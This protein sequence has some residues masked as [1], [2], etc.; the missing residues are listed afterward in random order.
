MRDKCRYIV[1]YTTLTAR[2]INFFLLRC[3]RS[4]YLR[5]ASANHEM[6]LTKQFCVSSSARIKQILDML[7]SKS[8]TSSSL[9]LQELTWQI[10]QAKGCVDKGVLE[11]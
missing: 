2:D 6:A 1:L 11:Y 4:L 10:I 8:P 9:A 7:E 5:T 3:T